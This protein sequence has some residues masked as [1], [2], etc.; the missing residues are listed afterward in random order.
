MNREDYY[1]KRDSRGG[2]WIDS[3][4]FFNSQSVVD[5][6]KEL[7]GSELIKNINNGKY[8]KTIYKI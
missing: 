8:R 1:L 7:R 2:I 5:V 3:K 4:K 6:I